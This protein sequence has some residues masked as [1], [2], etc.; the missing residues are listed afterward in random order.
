MNSKNFTVNS[1]YKNVSSVCFI[2]KT[3][4]EENDVSE[5]KIKEIEL[6]LAEALNN[7]IKHSYKGNETNK[8]DIALNFSDNDFIIS[9]T[10]YGESR[11]NLS[12]PVLEFD[13]DDIESL[14]EGGMGLFIIE[15]L[16]DENVYTIDGNKNIFKLVKHIK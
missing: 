5:D 10:D 1:A 11:K 15:Q 12:K 3:F 14:P 7:V 16:M 4:C 8:I 2:A 13:P 6:C 9:L